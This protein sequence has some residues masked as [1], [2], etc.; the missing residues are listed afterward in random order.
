MNAPTGSSPSETALTAA[1][2]PLDRRRFLRLAAGVAAAGPA[3]PW[4]R[5]GT[6][7]PG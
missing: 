2:A 5:P 3:A 1:L 4:T 6:P 7:T